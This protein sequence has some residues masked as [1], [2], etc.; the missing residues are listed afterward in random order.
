MNFFIGLILI[1]FMSSVSHGVTALD[2]AIEVGSIKVE[3]YNTSNTGIIHVYQCDSCTQKIYKFS[4]P[5]KVI[6]SG[7]V[8]TFEFFLKDYWNAKF[9][10]LLLDNKSLSVFQVVY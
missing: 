10:T 4:T 5:P 6:R 9:P 8:I 7:K 1:S 2:T 3:F